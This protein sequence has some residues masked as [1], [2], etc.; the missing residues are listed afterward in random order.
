M[1]PFVKVKSQRKSWLKLIVI[2]WI[3]G[4]G[5][6]AWGQSSDTPTP[7]ETPKALPDGSYFPSSAEPLTPV[8]PPGLSPVPYNDPSVGPNV[9]PNDLVP[10]LWFEAEYVSWDVQRNG[11]AP[12]LLT[13]GPA[14]SFGVVG[15]LGTTSL[16]PTSLKFAGIPGGRFTTGIWWT[17]DQVIGMDATFMFISRQ[18]LGFTASS[19]ANGDQ[20]LTRPF[21]DVNTNQQSGLSVSSPGAFAGSVTFQDTFNAWGAEINPL[22]IRLR[23][24]ENFKLYGFI[25]FRYMDIVEKLSINSYSYTLANGQA[26]FL[27]FPQ[28]PG[29]ALGVADIFDT[30]NRIYAGQFGTRMNFKYRRFGLDITTKAAIGSNYEV[31]QISG[32]TT[33]QNPPFQTSSLVTAGGLLSGPNNSFRSS[34]ASFI[35]VPEVNAKLTYNVTDRLSLM[36]GYNFLFLSNVIR[37]ENQILPYV[38][39]AFTPSSPTFGATNLPLQYPLPIFERTTMF[40]QGISFGAK[41][42]Y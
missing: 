37:P 1:I 24:G 6:P 38:N 10:R 14:S 15:N 7:T 3:V 41:F 39:P 2:G 30:G 21:Y 32:A 34:A 17:D 26:S 36:V 27:G 5:L 29:S 31:S 23:N 13:T 18:Q 22:L 19:D 35:V 42:V 25:G 12:N 11:L 4:C 9:S 28:G 20:T 16:T 33:S 8:N 40:I